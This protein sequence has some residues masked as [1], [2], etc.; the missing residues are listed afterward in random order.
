MSF[1]KPRFTSSCAALFEE[2]GN[3]WLSG[4]D[5][6]KDFPLSQSR[7]ADAPLSEHEARTKA[8]RDNLE[9]ALGRVAQDFAPPSPSLHVNPD[10]D[11]FTKATRARAK[12]IF[13][14]PEGKPTEVCY[15]RRIANINLKMHREL[16]KR[17]IV[18][19]K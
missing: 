2:K 9:E 11:Q 13:K 15:A 4:K 6:A 5:K 19:V 18:K 1:T 8:I 3:P 10:M 7:A 17:K 16:G 14:D 12:S